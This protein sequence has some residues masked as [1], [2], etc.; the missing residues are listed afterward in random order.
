MVRYIGQVDGPVLGPVEIPASAWRR[1]DV[2]RSLAARNMALLLRLV[3]SYGGISQVRMAVAAGLGQGRV[4]EIING[5]RQ[6]TGLGVFERI[7][8][9]LTMPDEA[10]ML[11]GLAPASAAGR[12]AFAGHAE[13]AQVFA[14]QAAA[15]R[16]LR[17]EAATAGQLDLMAVRAL[18]LIGLNDSLL[19]GSLRARE[20]PVRVRVLLLDPGAPAVAV[21]ASEIGESSESL[22]SGIRL[23]VARLAELAGCPG[24]DLRVRLY[25]DRPVWRMIRLDDI[26]YLSAFGVRSEGHRSGMYKLTAAENGV[27]HAGFTRHFD[28]AWDRSRQ[29]PEAGA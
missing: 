11:L 17:A 4:N 14:S 7:A 2:Q 15:E 16:D 21:R 28:D 13:I 12:G 23:A 29:P 5:R 27:L 9:G 24:V 3:Q 8:D 25:R 10:R 18:G 6:V 19:R 1:A 22:A 20:V 26:L